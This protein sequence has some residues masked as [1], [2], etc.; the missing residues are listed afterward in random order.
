MLTR[1]AVVLATGV[2]LTGISEVRADWCADKLYYENDGIV[3]AE[4]SNW[5]RYIIALADLRNE[6]VVLDSWTTPYNCWY[7]IGTRD[8]GGKHRL[9]WVQAYWLS[10]PYY[11]GVS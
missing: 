6:I 3:R 9:G 11:C 10:W 2:F 7:L 1:T 5:S 8:Y 4:P